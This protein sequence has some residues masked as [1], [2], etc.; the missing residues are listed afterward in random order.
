MKRVLALAVVALASQA[1]IS[2]AGG[3]E[4]SSKQVI[5]P[6]PPPASFFRGNEFDVGAFATYVTGT[7]GGGTRQTA[8]EDG[9]T[10]TLSSSGSPDGWGGGMDFT[11]FFPWKY[12]GVRFQGAGVELNT[13]T[14]TSP[15]AMVSVGLIQAVRRRECSPE[16]SSCDSPWMTSGQVFTWRRTHSAV[17]V[18]SSPAR[19]ITQ[20]THHFR[21]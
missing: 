14:L 21:R 8:F 11:Y 1:T 9:N 3:P 4:V 17:L 5:T 20:L 15:G 7:N 6:A 19:E 12:A 13:G 2:F 16:T 10:F 18:V